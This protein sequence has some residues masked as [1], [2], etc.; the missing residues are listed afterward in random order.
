MG[1]AALA[2]LRAPTWT[3]SS[4]RHLA[5]RE[6]LLQLTERRRSHDDRRDLWPAQEPGDGDTSRFDSSSSETFRSTRRIGSP[7]PVS[8]GGNA[9]AERRPSDAR[10]GSRRRAGSTPSPRRR[11]ARR[12]ARSPA[13]RLGRRVT[14]TPA[15]TSARLGRRKRWRPTAKPVSP[16]VQMDTPTVAPNHGT[17]ARQRV[18]RLLDGR[19][20]VRTVQVE[21]IDSIG[22]QT[23]KTVLD[24]R[25]HIGP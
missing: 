1:G 4:F 20:P 25:L 21:D 3:W 15:P 5:R 12:S 16:A 11:A 22:A 6:V 10:P 13:P 14:S 23:A 9:Q 24:T 18:E 2:S 19:R 17:R 7:K 8:T